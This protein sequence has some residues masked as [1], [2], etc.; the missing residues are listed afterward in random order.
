MQF[1]SPVTL[2]AVGI[3]I[4]EIAEHVAEGVAQLAISFDEA[5][6]NGLRHAHVFVEF[7]GCRPQAQDFGAVLL[8]DLFGLDGV[9]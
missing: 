1:A 6:L 2:S 4:R 7:D 9:A 5:R 3:E 8:D